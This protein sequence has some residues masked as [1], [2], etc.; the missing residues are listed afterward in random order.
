[1]S[2][3][4]PTD[5]DWKR[6]ADAWRAR[7]EHL[8][9]TVDRLRSLAVAGESAGFLAHE[10]NNLYTPVVGYCHAAQVAGADEAIK[11]KAIAKSL[12]AAERVADLAGAILQLA[13]SAAADAAVGGTSDVGACVEA[14]LMALGV[15]EWKREGI[16][17]RS[18][19]SR[20]TSVA[21]SAGVVQQVVMNLVLNAKHA[22][23][24][25]RGVID[26]CGQAV[27]GVV[28]MEV[29]DGGAGMNAK[30]MQNV[31]GITTGDDVVE[32]AAGGG[33]RYEVDVQE[34]ARSGSI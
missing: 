16:E 13:G 23:A 15:E 19:V 9:A 27:G 2:D 22:M 25:R 4:S 26:V 10:L 6:E 20:G 33:A 3:R 5:R 32:A 29:R 34:L 30:V 17:V 21:A 14:G 12:A 11:Q 24:G 1:M 28:R 18:S 31:F 7:A 8:Q